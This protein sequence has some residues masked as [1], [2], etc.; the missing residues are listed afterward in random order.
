MF[1][2]QGKGLEIL[3]QETWKQSAC[4]STCKVT[5]PAKCCAPSGLSPASSGLCESTIAAGSKWF[6]LL[7]I[8]IRPTNFEHLG[9]DLWML[10][11]AFSREQFL[12][13]KRDWQFST[14]Q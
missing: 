10:F 4:S 3:G 2:L 9:T 13:L 14:S 5:V 7:I 1:H 6:K 8:V 11:H 12:R